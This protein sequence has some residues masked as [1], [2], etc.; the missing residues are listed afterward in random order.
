VSALDE[1]LSRLR[2]AVEALDDRGLGAL[3][4]MCRFWRAGLPG[5]VAYL[6]DV[7]DAF[8]AVPVAALADSE[9]VTPAEVE[10]EIAAQLAEGGSCG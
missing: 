4:Q 7:L 10:A 5:E 2:V 8:R 1:P 3:Y 9:G 6:V